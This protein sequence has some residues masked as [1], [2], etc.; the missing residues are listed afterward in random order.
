MRLGGVLDRERRQDWPRATSR[1]P[2][3]VLHLFSA[4]S[5]SKPG[6]GYRSCL[7]SAHIR[8][9]RLGDSI[10]CTRSQKGLGGGDFLPDHQHYG[11][12]HQPL[13]ILNDRTK[14]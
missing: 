4:T 14:G 8:L 5:E 10:S 6:P 3:R 9:R 12:A 1:S 2:L 7:D 11:T 13:Q